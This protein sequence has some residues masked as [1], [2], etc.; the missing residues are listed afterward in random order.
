M[1]GFILRILFLCAFIIGF[2]LA[3]IFISIW[4]IKSIAMVYVFASI[5]SL[6]II[7]IA[8][9]ITAASFNEPISK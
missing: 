6:L 2:Y 9:F 3:G 7:G 8:F 4:Y 1:K 5:Y